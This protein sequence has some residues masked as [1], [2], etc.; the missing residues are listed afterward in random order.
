[1]NSISDRAYSGNMRRVS[2]A[3]PCPVCGKHDWC[4]ASVD[5]SAAICARVEGSKRC[6]E[7]GWLHRLTISP[8][9]RHDRRRITRIRTRLPLPDLT[10]LAER[11]R[12][13]L[14][15]ERLDS[16]AESLGLSEH[17]LTALRVGWSVD[18]R[19]W[20]FPMQDPSNGKVI[21]IR[22]RSLDGSKFAVTGGKEG[23]FIPT[24][25]ADPSDPLLIA[26]GATD[27]AALLDLGFANVVGRPNC[28]GGIKHL[29]ALVGVRRPTGVVIVADGDESG[30]TGAANLASV[31][32]V[33]SPEIRVIEPPA[34]VNDARSWKRTGASHADVEAVIAAAPA[35]RLIVS[36][37]IRGNR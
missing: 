1:M 5:G 26:E 37:T 6:G 16:L 4:L 14:V 20:T 29:V 7:A 2:P 17:S 23:L 32:Q 28:T 18:H 36:T 24:T 9:G 25:E 35:R 13:S 3:H 31:L 34:G 30:R 11:C 19:A 33:F 12:S 22:L 27:T 21:G 15:A 8:P 10:A